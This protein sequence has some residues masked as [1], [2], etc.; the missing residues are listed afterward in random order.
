MAEAGKK[1]PGDIAQI[2]TA[3]SAAVAVLASLA[4]T[5]VL[6]RAQRN[7]GYLLFSGLGLVVLGALAWFLATIL[8]ENL[9]VT[10]RSHQTGPFVL[11]L[12]AIA[13]LLFLGGLIIAIL[14]VRQTEQDAQRPAVAAS[15]DA[16]S[17][18]LKAKISAEGLGTDQRMSVRVD[19]LKQNGETAKLEL[20]E[21]HAPLYFAL[22]GP[23][24]DGKVK[25]EFSV[26]VPPRFMIVGVVA[27]TAKSQ[28]ACFDRPGRQA[29]E[30]GCTVVRLKERS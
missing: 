22:F 13:G 23:D 8:P 5:G 2:A 7:H 24:A 12:R 25:Y 1:A 4:V 14:A 20:V 11:G 29:K 16:A 6:A 27:W 10:R 15:F 30:A 18:V 9:T 21:P 28:P 3:A 17:G 26:Y 19:G